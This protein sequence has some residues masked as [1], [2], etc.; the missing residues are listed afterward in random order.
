M[1]VVRNLIE[2]PRIYLPVKELKPPTDSDP[3]I[4]DEKGIWNINK[5]Y[6]IE[7][8][9]LVPYD[10]VMDY[11]TSKASLRSLVPEE[12]RLKEDTDDIT[13]LGFK[14][15]LIR[16]AM[17]NITDLA[18]DLDRSYQDSN[19]R[20]EY[21]E[22]LAYVYKAMA[23]DAKDWAGEDNVLIF[24]PKNGGIFVQEVFEQEG[25]PANSFFDYRMSRVQTNDGGLM[26]GITIGDNNPKITDY[27]KFVFADDCMASDI[28]VS[29]TL[30][31]IREAFR[32][33]SISLSEVEI[34][35]TFSAATQRGLESL[36]SQKT[37]ERFG[38]KDMRAVTGILVYEMDDHFY[39]KHPDGKY[40]VADMGQWTETPTS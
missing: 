28:S 36:V 17:D 37:S 23:A 5:N 11:G 20:R 40:V 10:V 29:A 19:D 32:K 16:E 26:V 39:L 13:V 35:I 3:V 14:Q 38:F 33:E 18:N 12:Q 1:T 2:G 9:R 31:M 22:S 25:F 15:P 8:A 24:S 27:K 30:E 4:Q 7:G 21:R 34:L 6:A